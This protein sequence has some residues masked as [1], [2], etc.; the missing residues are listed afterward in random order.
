MSDAGRLSA[1]IRATIV[2]LALATAVAP[3]S[4]QAGRSRIALFDLAPGPG[5]A[6]IRP[7]TDAVADTMAL[8]LALLGRFEVIR[9]ETPDALA[10]LPALREYC[11]ANRIDQAVGGSGT[12]RAGGG[13][14]FRLGVYDRHEDRVTRVREGSSTGLLDIFEVTDELV[15]ELLEAL[16]GT[17]IGFGALE[18]QP[19]GERG[20]YAVWIDGTP[21]GTGVTSVDRLLIGR[22]TVSVRQ[23]RLLRE[24]E[25]LAAAP[26]RRQPMKASSGKPGS[27]A[28]ATRSARQG[29]CS[30][31][32]GSGRTS[33][34]SGRQ[35]RSCSGTSRR[36]R[37]RSSSW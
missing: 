30:P 6:G 24:V 31:R 10:D 25:L 27:C 20:E 35:R 14:S 4:A 11:A 12:P 5:G 8:T 29:R 32:R 22:R 23:R 9:L 37:A 16:S 3:L 18:L 28:R 26:C 13:Y 33:G 2:L 19:R 17:H 36:W 21:V 15:T 7:V 1:R 34:R